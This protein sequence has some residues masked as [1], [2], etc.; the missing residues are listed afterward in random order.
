MP[1]AHLKLEIME[2]YA[3]LLILCDKDEYPMQAYFVAGGFRNAELKSLNF[4]RKFI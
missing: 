4:I 1:N 3:D 2:D